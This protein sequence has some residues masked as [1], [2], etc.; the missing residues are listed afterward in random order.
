MPELTK[1]QAWLKRRRAELVGELKDIEDQLD[2]EPSKDWEDR[3]S[4]R[5]GDEV[6][7]T[8]GANDA[9]ELRQIDAA[10]TR[11]EEDTYG[12][13]VKCGS[14]ISAERLEALPATPFCKN[15]AV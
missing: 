5:Q 6:L 2:D 4:E 1:P 11:V 8:R 10:L 7:E 13:C 12:E 3:A 14:D 15:C 9:T